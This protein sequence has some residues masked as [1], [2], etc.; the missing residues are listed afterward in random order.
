VVAVPLTNSLT[1]QA[2]PRNREEVAARA[3]ERAAERYG[4]R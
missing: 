1:T 2:A 3:R 4:A